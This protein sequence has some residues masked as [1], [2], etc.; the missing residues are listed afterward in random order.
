[1]MNR[2][3][4]MPM[5]FCHRSRWKVLTECG[6]VREL[7]SAP[8]PYPCLPASRVRRALVL[9]LYACALGVKPCSVAVAM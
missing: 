3:R 8:A 1:M 6:N 5:P 2:S 7:K 4:P 9:V